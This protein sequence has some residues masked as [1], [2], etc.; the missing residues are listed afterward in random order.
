[1]DRRTLFAIIISLAFLFGWSLFFNKPKESQEPAQV[2]TEAG[3]DAGSERT[4]AGDAPSSSSAAPAAGTRAAFDSRSET[5]TEDFGMFA[6]DFERLGGSVRSIKLRNFF[7]ASNRRIDLVEGL[8]LREFSS[9]PF[10]VYFTSRKELGRVFFDAARTADG[11]VFTYRTKGTEG[12][13]AGLLVTKRF[14]VDTNSYVLKIGVSVKNASGRDIDM[15]SAGL[16]TFSINFFDAPPVVKKSDVYNQTVLS[17]CQNGKMV[18]VNS[19][20][21]VKKKFLEM[22]MANDFEWVACSSRYFVVS[23]IAFDRTVLRR[24]VFDISDG[25]YSIAFSEKA[26]PLLKKDQERKVEYYAYAGPKDREI[27]REYKKRYKDVYGLISFEQAMGFSWVGPISN[28]L[29][30]GL[31]LLHKIVPSYGWAII[32]LTFLIKLVFL[33]LSYKQYESMGRMKDLQPHLTALKEQYKNE[34]Q[35]L[36]Q[37]TMAIYKKYKIN[38]LGGCLPMLVQ[39]PVF[40]AFYDLLSKS[41]QLRGASFYWIKDL[42]NPDTVAWVGGFP[43]NIL[44]ILMA[45]TMFVQQ[46]WSTGDPQQKKIMAFMPL[47][48][49]FIFWNLPSGL[50]LYWT[51]QNILSIGEQAFIN[52]RLKKK[53]TA[54]A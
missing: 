11:V 37:E 35:R 27:F 25:V 44:P 45:G 6:V 5:F 32:L 12:L 46:L 9:F 18:K 17:F 42:A 34:P 28:L 19:A 53:K 49:L 30:D 23:L 8:S 47:I 52:S 1:M 33:P 48:F 20:P 26:K 54:A 4:I 2:R 43:L 31:D 50:T 13:P 40:F 39:I 36:N 16:D 24:P 41:I 3:A 10:S 21:K 7:A 14:S 15:E 22:T 29:L 38:P 51:C